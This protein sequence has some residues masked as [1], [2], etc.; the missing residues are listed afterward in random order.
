M[1]LGWRCSLFPSYEIE[2]H[3]CH[4]RACLWS[5][6]N[7]RL[8]CVKVSGVAPRV[9]LA[10]EREIIRQA[11]KCDSKTAGLMIRVRNGDLKNIGRSLM[12]ALSERSPGSGGA[13][14]GIVTVGEGAGVLA[15]GIRV[16]APYAQTTRR[17]LKGA[18]EDPNDFEIPDHVYF[19]PNK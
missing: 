3:H 7:R 12:E 16:V 11:G 15:D 19:R 17:M 14:G 6:D 10:T 5:L 13:A 18:M 8:Y 9:I 4:Q 2:K 1:T